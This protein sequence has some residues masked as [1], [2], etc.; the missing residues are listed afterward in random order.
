MKKKLHFKMDYTSLFIELSFLIV[1]ICST[2]LSMNN[3]YS[4]A[5]RENAKA[6]LDLYQQCIHFMESYPAFFG[7][8]FLYFF[9]IVMIAYSIFRLGLIIIRSFVFVDADNEFEYHPQIKY[10]L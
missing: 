5:T 10:L 6:F 7:S 8:T 2:K 3:V 4:Y 9:F 1:F